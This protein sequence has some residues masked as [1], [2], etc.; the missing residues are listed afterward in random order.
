MRKNLLLFIL[1]SIICTLPGHSQSGPLTKSK[2]PFYQQLIPFHISKDSIPNMVTVDYQFHAGNCLLKSGKTIRGWFSFAP[3]AEKFSFYFGTKL[4]RRNELYFKS[5]EN[6]PPDSIP[7]DKISRLALAGKDSSVYTS[8]DSTVF[9]Y[10]DKEDA[11]LR[12]RSEKP[13]PF[14]DDQLIVD[15]LCNRHLTF[16]KESAHLNVYS[17]GFGNNVIGGHLILTAGQKPSGSGWMLLPTGNYD[18][19]MVFSMSG[20]GN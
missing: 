8:E 2:I 17:G 20:R 9:I 6:S 18:Q 12:L 19:P 7:Q 15:E 5:A 4:K 10:N 13:V 14:Y 3:Y 1:L 11:L 16:W